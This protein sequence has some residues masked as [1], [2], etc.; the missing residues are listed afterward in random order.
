MV[1]DALNPLLDLLGRT[2][3]TTPTPA[4]LPRIGE[5]WNNSWDIVVAS[6]ALLVTIAGVIVMAHE[7]AQTRYSIKQLATRIPLG[8]IAAA[9]SLFVCGQAVVVANA[10]SRAVMGPGVDENT[11]S[12]TLR[13]LILSPINF[14][15][16]GLYL[17]LL[18]GVLAGLLVALLVVYAV[19]VSLTVIL[20]AGA[21]VALMCHALPQTEGIARWWWKAFGGLLAIQVV[22]SLT[23]ITAMRVFLGPGGFT[24]F[25]TT[26]TGLVN[27][28]VS[29]GLVYILFKTPFWILGSIGLSNKGNFASSL[30]R[31]YVVAKSMGMLKPAAPK[32]RPQKTTR[33]AS[34]SPAAAQRR[35]RSTSSSTLGSVPAA[36]RPRRTLTPPGQPLFLSPAPTPDSASRPAE[37]PSGPPPA[38]VFQEPGKPPSGPADRTPVPS[39]RPAQPP[40]P[41]AFRPPGGTPR[42]PPR[43]AP[44]SAP[45]AATFS[46][47]NR[48]PAPAPRPSGTPPAATF[49]PPATA[50]SPSPVR[51]PWPPA[52]PTFSSPRPAQPAKPP[53]VL[54]PQ[55]SPRRN[56]PGGEPR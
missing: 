55:R 36:G 53:R 8:F 54:P 7:T 39:P 2:L 21:P 30:A 9:M 27:L 56:S 11:A 18:G 15:S 47:P 22:Q 6:Y 5:L 4:Q 45:P 24:M 42:R 12:Q 38:P 13:N 49:S 46:S 52:T 33:S 25:D 14:Q 3:L 23:L 51:R 35:G 44:R 37:R 17:V 31:D 26:Q 29:L 43:T 19:R 50:P 1:S 48:P 16:G 32:S 28:V 20:I 10:L 41:P 40:G 34:A